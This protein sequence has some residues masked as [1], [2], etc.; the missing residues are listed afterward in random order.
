VEK[1]RA[2]GVIPELSFMLA[3][4][5][6]PEGETERTF[7]YIRHI[8]RIHPATEIMLYVYAPLPPAAGVSDEHVERVVAGLRDSRGQPLVFPTTAEEWAAPHWLSY[9]C[10]TDTPWLTPRLRRRILDFTTVLGCRFPTVTDV[11]SPE[12]G[13]VA[14][15]ALASWRYRY[16]RY[17]GPWELTAAKRF[18]RL[19]DPRLA[20]L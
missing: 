10:H 16:K 6:D 15:R 9:W 8:K 1:C 2:N 18:I 4:P 19:W 14:V 13:K 12:W 20:G 5:Q 3:P 17:R 11:R 7:E